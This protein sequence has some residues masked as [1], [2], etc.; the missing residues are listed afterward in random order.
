MIPT[1]YLYAVGNI[2]GMIAVALMGWSDRI[3]TRFSMRVPMIWL[4][5]ITTVSILFIFKVNGPL[6]R[7]LH[8]QLP[9][10]S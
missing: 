2:G 5:A 7:T 6:K 8:Q 9:V 4:L 1:G 10:R 3:D